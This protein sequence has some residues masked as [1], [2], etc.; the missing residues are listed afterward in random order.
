MSS[1]VAAVDVVVP[2]RTHGVQGHSYP[3][4]AFLKTDTCSSVV[5]PL[6]CTFQEEAQSARGC[7]GDEYMADIE[8]VHL[9]RCH[10]SAVAPIE[11][12]P[13]PG[14]V[15]V[16]GRGWASSIRS[17]ARS[18]YPSAEATLQ[19]LAINRCSH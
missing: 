19:A 16:D 5:R 2:H 8:F 15:E 18:T 7:L 17:H 14:V 13:P 12:P 6:A 9:R 11:H 10:T 4:H 3:M 1:S